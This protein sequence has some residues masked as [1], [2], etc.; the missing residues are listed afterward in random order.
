MA[1]MSLS[2]GPGIFWANSGLTVAPS[3]LSYPTYVKWYE[4]VHI[5]DWTSAKPGLITAAWRYQRSDTDDYDT[6]G[7]RSEAPFLVVYRY[8]DVADFNASEFRSV[9]L[10]NP[11]LPD[12]QPVTKFVEFHAV[13]GPLIET[14]KSETAPDGTL[15]HPHSFGGSLTRP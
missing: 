11:L 12:N 1:N 2:S 14:W 10:T 8:T 5:P 7:D 13:L 15:P 4:N 3:V 9:P 6:G